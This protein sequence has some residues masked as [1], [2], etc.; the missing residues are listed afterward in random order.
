MDKK[1]MALVMTILQLLDKPIAASKVETTYLN[2]CIQIERWEES[3]GRP[4]EHHRQ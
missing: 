2:A 4:K 1:D 3:Q